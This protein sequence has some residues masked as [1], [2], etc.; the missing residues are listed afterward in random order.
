MNKAVVVF[1]ANEAL[2]HQVA[3]E[4]LTINGSYV[5]ALLLSSPITKVILSNVPL[6]IDDQILLNALARYDK[7]IHVIKPIPLGCKSEKVKHVM[8]SILNNYGSAIDVAWN[9]SIDGINHVVFASTESINCFL[10][11]SYGYVR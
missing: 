10:C 4:G 11:G 3:T 5:T 9:F 6:Y 8:S 2:V 1:L 7:V